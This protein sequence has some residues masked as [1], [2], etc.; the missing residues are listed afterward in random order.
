MQVQTFLG[1]CSGS[2]IS[3]RHILTAYHCTY[4][5]EYHCISKRRSFSKQ[6]DALF[7]LICNYEQLFKT[8]QYSS[9]LQKDS[10]LGLACLCLSLLFFNK[11]LSSAEKDLRGHATILRSIQIGPAFQASSHIHIHVHII[12]NF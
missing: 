6:S 7:M 8:L 3:R 12:F 10:N 4:C 9:I 1:L 11:L 2:L 5:I